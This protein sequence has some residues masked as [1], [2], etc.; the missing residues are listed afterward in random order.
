MSD[1]IDSKR[2]WLLLTDGFTEK[3]GLVFVLRILTG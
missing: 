2:E 3:F 1:Q